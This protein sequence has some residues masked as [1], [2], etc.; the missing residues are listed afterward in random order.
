MRVGEPEERPARV[1]KL[2]WE[3]ASGS[4]WVGALS[5]P[6]V[7]GRVGEEIMPGEY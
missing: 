2:K 4:G 6:L 7:Y 1:L 3:G 5:I